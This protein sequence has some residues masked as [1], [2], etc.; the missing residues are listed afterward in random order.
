M[1]VTVD[2][3]FE[4]LLKELDTHPE[5]KGYYRFLNDPKSF[6]FRKAYYVQRLQYI[7]DQMGDVHG[8]VWDIGCGYGTTAIFLA[9]NGYKVHGSTLEYYFK[10]IPKRLEYW[11]KIG[12]IS[13]FTFDY[14]NLFDSHPQPGSYSAVI[15]QDTLHH[16][17]PIEEALRIIKSALVPCGKV[18]AVEENGNNWIQS[19]K[20]YMQ[21]GNKRIIDYHDER[22]GKTIKL[23]NENIRSLAHWTKL[24]EEAG[25]HIPHDTVHYVR[26][27]PPFLFK[28]NPD[29]L[30][31]KEQ[32]K[33][34]SSSF[35]RERFF[36]GLDFCAIKNA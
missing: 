29:A 11:S 35:L 9:L 24:F 23:G 5:L 20:L 2:Q 3:F 14:E 25:Y 26:L 31:A 15:V 18:I 36:F 27:Y 6:E 10:E 8:K 4:H 13:G 33:W 16:T 7:A 19:A 22:L 1:K 32:S 34:K 12:D 28:G 21:R 17:E 30:I